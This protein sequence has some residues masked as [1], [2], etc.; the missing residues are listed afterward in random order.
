MEDADET[1]DAEA[2][3]SSRKEHLSVP[4]ASQR[5]IPTKDTTEEAGT[6]KSAKSGE[7]DKFSAKDDK[8]ET[9][10]SSSEV[11]KESESQA[12]PKKAAN[13]P[14]RTPTIRD[15][16]IPQAMEDARTTRGQVKSSAAKDSLVTKSP[17]PRKEQSKTKRAESS[18]VNV[19]RD[20]SGDTKSEMASKES[21]S[22]AVGDRITVDQ[23]PKEPLVADAASAGRS[24]RPEQSTIPQKFST[25]S[26]TEATSIVVSTKTVPNTASPSEYLSVATI[27]AS[28]ECVP[29]P[30]AENSAT[31]AGVRNATAPYLNAAP[32]EASKA[33]QSQDNVITAEISVDVKATVETQ[34]QTQQPLASI[35]AAVAPAVVNQAPPTSVHSVGATTTAPHPT[36]GAH[37]VTMT[38]S[39]HLVAGTQAQQVLSSSKPPPPIIGATI[40]TTSTSK[41]LN[42]S[43]V[44]TASTTKSSALTEAAASTPKAP[45][46]MAIS[47]T[48]VAEEKVDPP[49][50]TTAASK[51]AAQA[52]Q[53]M[54]TNASST[55]A[56]STAAAT[57]IPV[58][59]AAK[60]VAIVL[61]P[62]T[63]ARPPA[64][65]FQQA[66]QQAADDEA[67]AIARA[68]LVSLY[69]SYL[70]HST[71]SSLEDA[72][73]RLKKAL[74]QTRILRQTFTE[75]VY[76]K[77]R[78]CLRPPPTTE[79]IIAN[80][81]ADPVSQLR[82]LKEEMA[83][84]REEK[85][86]EKKEA[87]KLNNEM[88]QSGAVDRMPVLSNIDN[89]EQLM[90][91]TAGL[92]LVILPEE[93]F[94]Q[95]LLRGY[96]DLSP[97][98]GSTGQ[99]GRNISQ[100]A[101]TAGEVILDRTR[102]AAAMRVERQRRRQ[103]QLLRGEVVADGEAESNYSR[104]Q[105][106][107]IAGASAQIAVPAVTKAA[108]PPANTVGTKPAPSTFR[109]APA[110]AAKGGRSRTQ[111]SLPANILL[112]LNPTADEVKNESKPCAA[113]MA[114]MARG[115]GST[116]DKTTQQRLRH[117]HPESLGGRR[118]ASINPASAKK[119]DDHISNPPEPFLQAYLANT[120]PPL[121]A[122]RERLERKPL[123]VEAVENA[124]S[125][126]ARKSIHSVLKYFVEGDDRQ[127]LRPVS[128]ISLLNGLRRLDREP[129]G[130]T[131]PSLP[132]NGSSPATDSVTTAPCVAV[133]EPA[134]PD[135]P[136]NPALTLS[137]LHAL[138]IIGRSQNGVCR[139]DN[140]VPILNNDNQG[141]SS[142]KLKAL[143]GKIVTGETTLAESLIRPKM[144]APSESS[145]KR[146]RSLNSNTNEIP[147]KL[148]REDNPE[149]AACT[150]QD[151]KA[152]PVAS[153]RGGGENAGD[154]GDNAGE[155]EPITG[156]SMAPKDE[157][158][159]VAASAV[160]A[161]STSDEPKKRKRS[162]SSPGRPSAAPPLRVASE[163]GPSLMLP[164]AAQ[165]AFLSSQMGS[166]QYNPNPTMNA[167]HI[168]NQ[169]RHMHHPAAG[170]LA[171]YLGSFQQQQHQG[172]DLSAMMSGATQ[173]QL[174][175]FG[176]MQP[177]SGMVGYTLQGRS[178]IAS[179]MLVR[180]Q[181]AAAI[182]G[183]Y[184]SP[185]AGFSQVGPHHAA[186]LSAQG[187]SV[188]L[189]Q[190]Q[191][192]VA[193][194]GGHPNASLLQ[195]GSN[196]K[197]QSLNRSEQLESNKNERG[198]RPDASTSKMP[199]R[200]Q[201][202][203]IQCK[204]EKNAAVRPPAE[205]SKPG[206]SVSKSG[207]CRGKGGMK[208]VAP[209][210][211]STLASQRADLILSGFFHKV[212]AELDQSDYNV[213]LDFLLSVGA[214]V[215]IPKG[216]VLSPL[217]ERLN[218]PGFK[219]AGSNSAPPITRDVVAAAI[220]VWL[221]ATH[222]QSFQ[223]AFE[224]NGRIDVD[225]DCKW[226]VQAAV[227]TAVGELSLE[228]AESMARGEGAFAE[229]SAARKANP[230]VPGVASLPKS[231]TA[232]SSASK[233]LDVCTASIVS[234]SLAVQMC[235]DG[236]MNFLIPKY[237]Q[238]VEFLDEARLGALRT[239]SQERT[240]LATLIARK[241]MMTEN[242]AHVYVSSMVRA[243]EALGH[244]RL[245][246]LAQDEDVMA[247]T[248]I[249]YDIFTDDSGSWEDPCKPIDGFTAGLSGD[250]LMRRA[251]A[252]AM[253]QKSLRKLQDR[254]HIRGGTSI[255][256]PFV[257]PSN[258][259]YSLVKNCSDGRDQASSVT[260]RPGVKRRVSTLAEP[261]V[262]PG[263][264][265]AIAKSW[266]VYDPKHFC[267]PVEWDPDD[268]ENSPYGLYP[269]GERIR[270]MSMAGGR[271][272]QDIGSKKTQ[273]S[274]SL[275]T[276]QHD[277]F[278][279][280]DVESRIIPSTREIDWADVASI[281]Q[282]VEVPRR[283][284]RYK[285]VEPEEKP[286]AVDGTIF[287]PF[288]REIE[289][290]LSTD[291]AESDTE[292]DLTEETILTRHHFV[293]DN[294]KATHDAFLEARKKQQELRK[295]RYTK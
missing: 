45:A 161:T 257:D 268:L 217:K 172:Y 266:T 2:P 121:P 80:I 133:K 212:A 277:S 23:P 116:A 259:D 87:A 44:F 31:K 274:V 93:Q 175:A 114:L 74:V 189:G 146:T 104:L 12:S 109:R 149:T 8:Q 186:F 125:D 192:Q 211:P 47:S 144:Q 236:D 213:A 147:S 252:R 57:K 98:N 83:A 197:Q 46:S 68:P 260:P 278:A 204:S 5:G 269:R 108:K 39:V 15:A 19:R 224:K 96:T 60:P 233:K 1:R 69:G 24:A 201:T 90:F 76:G 89:A 281:F 173:S 284:S 71:D 264:G 203:D 222:E 124:A 135:S 126:R 190:P 293:L 105:V 240:L 295:N 220:L 40:L 265:S 276:S 258:G 43:I 85:E 54:N 255:Y 37:S 216:L 230:I 36:P 9:K 194:S 52:S 136:L 92:N 75:R 196:E 6:A 27:A 244:G 280:L 285:A 200:A 49:T 180:E 225:P 242:F 63:D 140:V 82:K 118:R 209:T 262:V 94:D 58:A 183:G 48:I 193:N 106:L 294:M 270:S 235:I 253:I 219:N 177:N 142:G 246:E 202:D 247:S 210:V 165:M 25:D 191:I 111:A 232:L 77:Y 11:S 35:A 221:W 150:D 249:P 254:H 50:L 55:A 228:I 95:Q 4:V 227:D 152:I 218:T 123:A 112:S 176:F 238:L 195:S 128:K 215:P 139:T 132:S 143:R 158:G 157:R 122:T 223:L 137:V 127:S 65:S 70:C 169:L 159:A 273:R 97:G 248:M 134:S 185:P 72:R 56:S 287:A 174:S 205:D 107:S 208:F 279:S 110:A 226:L 138:G 73:N 100:A 103:L 41:P 22:A 141:L 286:A 231:E 145:R 256:G 250:D 199:A 151:D 272:G 267:S 28:A 29:A 3:I 53:S 168:A 13:D 86:I 289:G 88:N 78:V 16:I 239:K 7:K 32:S 181:Q 17:A 91:L 38:Q 283:S 120:L 67:I 182:L 179:A 162:E 113:T 102:K 130:D 160:S 81:Q 33:S 206:A 66:T 241:T 62:A 21:G 187:A 275:S 198:S 243:G 34:T 20:E 292:E 153:I 154:A 171:E 261:P 42:A 129:I 164:G 184:S 245:F 61:P 229:A 155:S 207:G 290:E 30:L 163:Q 156:A 148:S 178:A 18:P 188:L 14:T 79:E 119:D 51:V 291:N 101:A 170:D 251:H 99:R 263:T 117:P 282:S 115:V 131:K 26:P 288:C 166:D 167:F 237:P 271:S 10:G 64:A 84:I 59:T 234:Q 214:A